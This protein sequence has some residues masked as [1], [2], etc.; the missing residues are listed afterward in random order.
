MY[1]PQGQEDRR[2][3]ACRFFDR[4]PFRRAQVHGGLP[5]GVLERNNALLAQLV[6]PAVQT[7]FETLNTL[8]V[9]AR[10]PGKQP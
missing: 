2:A 10:Q 4:C 5:A 6:P 1:L 3:C 8:C 9:G 7:A